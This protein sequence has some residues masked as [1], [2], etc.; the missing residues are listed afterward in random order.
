[1]RQSETCRVQGIMDRELANPSANTKSHD[2]AS[3]DYSIAR[4]GEALRI[5]RRDQLGQQGLRIPSGGSNPAHVQLQR[6][7]E[8]LLAQVFANS[9]VAPGSGTGRAESG[10][11]PQFHA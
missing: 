4:S 6:G 5:A 8:R 7:L 10:R 3:F 1:M 9:P 11:T 2:V